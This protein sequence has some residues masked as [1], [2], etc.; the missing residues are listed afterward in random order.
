MTATGPVT[1]HGVRWSV[2][3][4]GLGQ[5]LER[6]PRQSAMRGHWP[7][8]DAAGSC[9]WDSG[10]GGAIRRAAEDAIEDHRREVAWELGRQHAREGRPALEVED[11]DSGLLMDLLGETGPTTRRN[12]PRR[13]LLCD[14]YEN[15]HEFEPVGR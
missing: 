1:R 9:G 6:I 5:P 8:Y 2:Y 14:R 7:G 3:A 15:S 4:D 10:T 13:W 11:G 12:H